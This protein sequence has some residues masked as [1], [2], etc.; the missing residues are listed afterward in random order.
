MTN[1]E[2]VTDLVL[3]HL[4]NGT[5][6]WQTPY[7]V[8]RGMPQNLA[9]GRRYRGINVWLLGTQRYDNPYWITY[10]Q[11][12]ALGG[13]IRKG[14]HGTT[15][16]KFGTMDIPDDATGDKKKRMFLKTYTVFNA[17]QTEQI[18]IPP[19][20]PPP[21]LEDA[22]KSAE[23][24]VARMKRPP[25]IEHNGLHRP[26]YSRL[27]DLVR[28]PLRSQF[29][30]HQYYPTLFHELV[31]ATGHESRLNRLVPPSDN[32]DQRLKDYSFEE[33]VAEMGSAYLNAHCGLHQQPEQ[34]AAY[35]KGWADVL[36][37]KDHDTWVVKAAGKAQQAADYILDEPAPESTDDKSNEEKKPDSTEEATP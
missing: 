21:G 23:N 6:P 29:I 9:T 18:A 14:E 31:H 7:L 25:R 24:V 26:S 11:A 2:R 3:Q 33:L 32:K 12:Q 10:Q 19:R 16:M 15:I 34:E 4:K 17:R 35:I 13:H 1:Y 37:N 20:T 28:M 5:V 27:E 36:A 8:E 30:G 22:I